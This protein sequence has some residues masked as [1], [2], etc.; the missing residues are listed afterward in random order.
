MGF[1]S[2]EQIA[3]KIYSFDKYTMICAGG[4]DKNLRF[5]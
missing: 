4:E 3:Q 2:S 5:R 1:S